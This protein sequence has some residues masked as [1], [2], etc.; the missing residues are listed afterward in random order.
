[1]YW[2]DYIFY[3]DDGLLVRTS[4]IILTAKT[5]N[6]AREKVKHFQLSKIT[7]LSCVRI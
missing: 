5:E 1:M 4:A 7:I 2:I 6:E 3:N